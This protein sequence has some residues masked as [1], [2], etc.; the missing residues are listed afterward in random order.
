LLDITNNFKTKTV[1]TISHSEATLM[2]FKR[3]RD[4]D[5]DKRRRELML[6]N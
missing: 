6:R 2:M 4:F 1:V 5:Y 3:I